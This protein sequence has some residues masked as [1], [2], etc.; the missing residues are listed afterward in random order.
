MRT[1]METTAYASQG[2]NACM[3]ITVE[4]LIMCNVTGGC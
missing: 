4:E 1:L 3:E 2:H